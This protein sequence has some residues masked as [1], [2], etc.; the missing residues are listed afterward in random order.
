MDNVAQAGNTGLSWR[1]HRMRGW[2]AALRKSTPGRRRQGSKTMASNRIDEV[3]NRASA[4]IDRVT[5]R[6]ESYEAD[7][8][9][10]D[11]ADARTQ[12]MIDAQKR[13]DK[14]ASKTRSR[15]TA[16]E[17]QPRRPTNHPRRFTSTFC[18]RCRR[19]F[20]AERRPEVSETSSMTV[21]DFARIPMN[22][23]VGEGFDPLF[24]DAGAP[25]AETPL[26]STPGRRVCGTPQGRRHDRAGPVAGVV[27]IG[28][29]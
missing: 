9:R 10:A 25:Q 3:T 20:L 4:A 29:A 8:R 22:R 6:L 24:H 7:Q 28:L 26:V 17:R 27:G 13:S 12:A 2:C 11:E 16:S 5:Q 19:C 15:P 23:S 1:V 14:R 21:G 18:A